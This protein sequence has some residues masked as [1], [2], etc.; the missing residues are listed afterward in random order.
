MINFINGQKYFKNIQGMQLRS[1]ILHDTSG[2][3]ADFD[4]PSKK[5]LQLNKRKNYKNLWYEELFALKF[6]I[7][8][9]YFH[10]LPSQKN[11][12]KLT[13]KLKNIL[14]RHST[15]PYSKLDIRSK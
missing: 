4:S 1:A 3:M 8:W 5:V 12:R 15:R 11:W 10:N 6:P 14:T 13:S 7:F 9:D 2:R